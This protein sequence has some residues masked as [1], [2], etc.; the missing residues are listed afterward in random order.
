MPKVLV[1]LPVPLNQTGAKLLKENGLE[2][3]EM[4]EMSEDELIKAIPTYDA[5]IVRSGTKV[6]KNA[7]ESAKNLK[8]IGWKPKISFERALAQTID[9]AYKIFGK[10][11]QKRNESVCAT[12][13]IRDYDSLAL[14]LRLFPHL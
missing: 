7:L 9:Y 12:H 2:F 5:L 1:L 6:T 3:A 10:G 13:I 14:H 11:K 4:S 8:V